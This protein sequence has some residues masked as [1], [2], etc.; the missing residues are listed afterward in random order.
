MGNSVGAG[1]EVCHGVVKPRDT[2]LGLGGDD[3]R[4]FIQVSVMS[5]PC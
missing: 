5:A 2:L 3:L 4:R 1:I